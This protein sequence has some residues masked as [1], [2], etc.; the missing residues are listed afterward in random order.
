[1]QTKSWWWW[2]EG[3]HILS[4]ASDFE[5]PCGRVRYSLFW[6]LLQGSSVKL[7]H[8]GRQTTTKSRNKQSCKGISILNI[9]LFISTVATLQPTL[10]WSASLSWSSSSLPPNTLPLTWLCPEVSNESTER[11]LSE[12][13]WANHFFSWIQFFFHLI[14]TKLSLAGFLNQVHPISRGYLKLNPACS[15]S[16]CLSG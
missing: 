15:L 13:S 7:F 9:I 6:C 11:T 4:T 8:R 1:M 2:C 14:Y 12:L 10:T 5:S 3:V 16:H